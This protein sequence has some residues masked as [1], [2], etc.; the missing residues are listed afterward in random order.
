MPTTITSIGTA[1]PAHRFSQAQIAR[2]MAKAHQMDEEQARHLHILYRATG[3]RS[4]YSV[5]SDYGKDKDFDF[6]PN[7]PDFEPFPDTQLR[8]QLYRRE[9]LPLALKAATHCLQEGGCVASDI[10]HLIV[11]SCTGMYAPGLDIDLQQ[12]LGLSPHVER[13]A[14]QFMGC[15]AAFNGMKLADAICKGTPEAKVLVVCVEL[16]SIHFQKKT[17]DDTLLA[18][19]L[20]GDGAACLLM[21]SAPRPGKIG[22]KVERFRSML[23]PDGGKEMAW[24]IGNFGFEMKLSAYVPEKIKGA[25]MALAAQLL[26][27]SKAPNEP[28]A[29]YAVH[30]GGKR[31][32]EVVEAELGIDK[33]ANKFAYQVLNEF[34]NM[35]SPTIL[36]VLKKLLNALQPSDAGKRVVGFAFGPGLTLESMLLQITL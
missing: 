33:E 22:L 4:R 30:P 20:F 27:Q 31:I 8:M 14:I 17:T 12:S 32:L 5:L 19:A 23:Q 26:Q 28:I 11:V 15:Y 1:L 3:I 2:F 21:E 13:T 29:Y 35:S 7:S 6:Y 16:C 10:T 36:F 9:A 24:E 25:I 18:N 34:G